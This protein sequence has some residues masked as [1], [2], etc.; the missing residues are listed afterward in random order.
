MLE[1]SANGGYYTEE[2]LFIFKQEEYQLE[3]EKKPKKKQVRKKIRKPSACFRP[4]RKTASSANPM[5]T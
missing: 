5:P 3:L 1:E 4:A 2:E